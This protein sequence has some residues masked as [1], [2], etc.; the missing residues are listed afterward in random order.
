VTAI[1]AVAGVAF[2]VAALVVALALANGFRDEMRDKILKGTS[3]ITLMRRDGQPISDWR[4]TCNDARKV[5]GVVAAFPTTYEGALITGPAGS[6]Y[7]VL[8]GVDSSSSEAIDGIRQTIVGGSADAL[9]LQVGGD[10]VTAISEQGALANKQ[11][12]KQEL[13][14]DPR[15]NDAAPAESR[16]PPVLVGSELASRTG[17][18]VGSTAT[19]VAS[20]PDVTPNGIAPRYITVRVVGIFRSGLYE[21]DSSWVYLPLAQVA[22]FEGRP[23]DSAGFISIELSDIY[24]A[25]KISE[26]LRQRFGPDYTTVDWQEA[27]RPLFAALALERRMAIFIIGLIVAVAV[28]NI[29]G[30]LVLVVVERR[31][32][33]AIL[34]AMGAR[35]LSIMA[36]FM[37][38][39]AAIG[40]V[41]ALA[42]IAFGLLISAI[43]NHYRLVSLPSDVYSVGNVPFHPHALEVVAGAVMAFVLSV[44]ATIYPARAAARI[45]PASALKG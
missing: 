13:E 11:G 21:Y 40:T 45:R 24:S 9:S 1:A 3:H 7:G 42:G 8:R 32:D 26:L 17:L 35:R 4:A 20:E 15:L 41:G 5:P 2:G 12:D 38:E 25:P 10:R 6:A 18:Q 19:L 28:L 27:N 37:L 31:N 39:G 29:T 23:A 34:A 14:S 16:Q 36:I 30:M 33:I 22:A 44:L 43:G